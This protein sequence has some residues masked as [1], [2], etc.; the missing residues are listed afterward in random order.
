MSSTCARQ[1]WNSGPLFERMSLFC[2]FV[3]PTEGDMR[4]TEQA[5]QPQK[6]KKE[7]KPR[8]MPKAG[9]YTASDLQA[10]GVKKTW[11][12]KSDG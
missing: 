5:I 10:K 6:A 2:L 12:E 11:A 9:R 3:R 4:Y 8:E 1:V 7:A